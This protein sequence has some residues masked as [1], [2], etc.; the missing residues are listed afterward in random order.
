MNAK[1]LNILVFS[2]IYPPD[3]GSGTF[4]SL[5]FFNNIALKGANIYLITVKKESF[6]SNASIDYKLENEINK[7]I[8]IIRTSVFRPAEY[9]A[10]LMKK[11]CKYKKNENKNFNTEQNRNN[12]SFSIKKFIYE[13]LTCPDEH[14]GW[15]YYSLKAAVKIV[16]KTKINCMYA[17][18]GPWSCILA[19]SIFRILYRIPLVLD[20]RDPWV[21]NPNF[22]HRGK[23]SQ[24]LQ[25]CMEYFCIKMADSI[26]AN[27]DE[28]R[29][30]FLSRYP[31][32]KN[33][34]V[35]CITNGFENIYEKN[36]IKNKKFTILH[37]GELYLHRNPLQILLAIKELIDFGSIPNNNIELIL[38]GGMSIHDEELFKLIQSNQFSNVLKLINRVDHHEIVEFQKKSDVLLIIQY[39]FPLQIPRKFYEYLSFQ[40]NILAVTDKGSATWNI[41]NNNNLGKVVENKSQ[42]IKCVLFDMYDDWINENKMYGNNNNLHL[43]DNNFLSEKLIKVFLTHL[44]TR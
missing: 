44:T 10:N 42:Y 24:L 35:L 15:I 36:T 4:R 22:I 2:Y 31:F 38:V 29:I 37:A 41:I 25:K 13:I 17:T 33:E 16:K 39:G 20:F 11:K 8:K 30:N 7:N 12:T 27:T 19:A 6:N 21:E 40:K 3:A 1:E 43:F 26:I 14:V 23:A 5:Y 18:G 32:L 34:N 28:L 9:L